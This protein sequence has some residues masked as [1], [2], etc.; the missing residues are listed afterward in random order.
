MNLLIAQALPELLVFAGNYAPVDAADNDSRILQLLDWIDGLT[1]S[2][3]PDGAEPHV[4]LADA[5]R[6]SAIA[7]FGLSRTAEQGN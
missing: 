2:P 1:E 6:L 5:K 4:G 7:R 3:W